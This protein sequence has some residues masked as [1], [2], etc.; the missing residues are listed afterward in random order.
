MHNLK[1]HETNTLYPPFKPKIRTQPCLKSPLYSPP[2]L[3][4][5]EFWINHFLSFATSAY[6]PK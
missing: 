3:H 4:Y 6:I 2:E 5:L 1:K